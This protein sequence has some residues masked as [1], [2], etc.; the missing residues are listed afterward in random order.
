ME[1]EVFK[2]SSAQ[3]PKHS[4]MT[5]VGLFQ[6]LKLAELWKGLFGIASNRL[7]NLLSVLVSDLFL[8]LSVFQIFWYQVC[9]IIRH[10]PEALLSFSKHSQQTCKAN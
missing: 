6:I 7:C 3:N 9:I 4:P 1:S 10:I 5:H 2:Q 8:F